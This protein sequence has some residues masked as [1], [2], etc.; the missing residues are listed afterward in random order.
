MR[1]SRM[2]SVSAPRP[3]DVKKLMENLRFKAEWWRNIMTR[4]QVSDEAKK[5]EKK[6]VH[7]FMSTCLTE[8]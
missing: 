2:S 4:E 6:R 7:V 1:C 5:K 8:M 3:I